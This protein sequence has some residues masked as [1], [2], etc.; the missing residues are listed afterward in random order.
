MTKINGVGHFRLVR[1]HSDIR[2]K[3]IKHE[4]C[5]ANEKIL[6]ERIEIS[7]KQTKETNNY[8]PGKAVKKHNITFDVN[9]KYKNNLTHFINS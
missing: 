2:I 1:M 6:E 5:P 4:Y 7:I 9:F 8:C 3:A